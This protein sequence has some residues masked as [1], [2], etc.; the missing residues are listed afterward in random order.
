ME[1]EIPYEKIRSAKKIGVQLPN[2]LKRRAIEICQELEERGYQVL[3]SGESC[4]GACDVDLALL[5]EVDLLLHF[6]HTPIIE[7]ERVVYVP[8]FIDY[9]PN[10]SLEIEEKRI[11]LISNAQFC[12]KLPDVK[13]SLENQG[14]E[15]ELK[16]GSKRI[17]FPGQVLGCNYSV[18]RDTESEAVIYVGDGEFHPIGA[19]IY[20]G[21]KVYAFNPITKGLKVVNGSDFERRRYFEV[22]RCVGLKKVGILVSSKP[23][24]KR[25]SLALKLEKL[26]KRSN[27]Q[28][29]LIYLNEITPQK[30]ENLPFE[31]YVNTACPRITYDDY[32]NFGKPLISPQE[33]EFLLGIRDKIGID[34]IY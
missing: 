25:T 34:E 15:V 14:Y 29:K 20:S 23:G 8:Y 3:I 2:G 18:L 33:F 27:L 26:A 31:F 30:I 32:L 12:H 13:R 7:N 28:A 19:S 22:S 1:F 4:Y 21:K 6:A 24:Q 17:S 9:D 11:A 16:R 10:F 5:S